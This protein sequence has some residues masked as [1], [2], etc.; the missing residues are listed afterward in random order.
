MYD[1]A[2]DI[3][4]AARVRL[5]DRIDTSQALS[6]TI[7]ENTDPWSRIAFNAA[8]RKL[9]K[10]LAYQGFSRLEVQADFTL[11]AV[12]GT[13]PTTQVFVGFDT[14][15][16][17]PADLLQPLFLWERPSGSNRSFIDMDEVLN[18]L[19][20]DTKTM[21]LKLWEWRDDRLYFL[22]AV[23]PV[24]VRL[25]YSQALADLVDD[26]TNHVPWFQQPV[27]ILR[28]EDSL[29]DYICREVAIAKGLQDAALAF[30]ESAEQNAL[31]IFGRQTEQGSGVETTSQ[32]GKMKDS[33][34]PAEP[35]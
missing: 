33:R 1:I 12:V 7:L 31:K 17:L 4:N 11:P 16:A 24:D 3:L 23:V 20:S 29:A 8:Y 5:N 27:E 30:E 32:R 10:F 18:G 19:P 22:G 26:D 35:R 25:R 9:Q 34:T 28:C 15:P 6:G 14:T 13:D 2:N 21:F